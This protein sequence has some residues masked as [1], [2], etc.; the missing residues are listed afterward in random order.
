MLIEIEG[1]LEATESDYLYV[2]SLGL[3]IEVRGIR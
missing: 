2:A 1:Y 3:L